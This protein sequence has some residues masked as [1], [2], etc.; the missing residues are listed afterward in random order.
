MIQ[1]SSHIVWLTG[2]VENRKLVDY[3]PLQ[4]VLSCGVFE[5]ESVLLLLMIDALLAAPFTCPCWFGGSSGCDDT[6]H[7][8]LSSSRW[9]CRLITVF[10]FSFSLQ[11]IGLL[12]VF[13]PQK[14]LEE[15]QDVWVSV[16]QMTSVCCVFV[17][18]IQDGARWWVGLSDVTFRGLWFVWYPKLLLQVH[19]RGSCI[20]AELVD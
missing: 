6:I 1:K 11:I 10:L 3:L 13:T 18:S 17:K 4:R 9:T 2:D 8:Q 12:N 16:S 7:C 19:S 5:L 14:T 20:S 15:F